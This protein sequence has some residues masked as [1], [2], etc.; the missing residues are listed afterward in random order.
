MSYINIFVLSGTASFDSNGNATINYPSGYTKNNCAVISFMLQGIGGSKS[1]S[2]GSVFDSS[3]TISGSVP[4]S[5]KL[6]DSDITISIRHI[7]ISNGNS[8]VVSTTYSS[9]NYRIVLIKIS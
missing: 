2:T 4:K 1:W 3:N 6:N 5:I 8:P 9:M 7:M